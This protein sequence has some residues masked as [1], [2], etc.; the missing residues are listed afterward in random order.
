MTSATTTAIF[1][2]ALAFF[3]SMLVAGMIKITYLTVRYFSQTKE[4]KGK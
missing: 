1:I 3:L 2:F 4:N